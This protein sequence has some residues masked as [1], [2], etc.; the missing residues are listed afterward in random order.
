MHCL[1]AFADHAAFLAAGYPPAQPELEA[2]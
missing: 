2:A 1:C